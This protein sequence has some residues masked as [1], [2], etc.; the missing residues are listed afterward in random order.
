MA[1]STTTIRWCQY[2]LTVRYDRD[3]PNL[4]YTSHLEIE[5]IVP[6]RG[7]LPITETG[8]RSH[9]VHPGDVEFAGSPAAYVEAWLEQAAKSDAWKAH[10]LS[11]LQM[12]LF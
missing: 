2:L 12:S 7:R 6:E 4:S 9:F 1:Y 3:W 10:E 8:Y 5:C 11:Q